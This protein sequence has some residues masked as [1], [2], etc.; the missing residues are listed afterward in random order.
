MK[1]YEL[2]EL[3][4]LS[5]LCDLALLDTKLNY[6]FNRFCND[7]EQYKALVSIGDLET[8]RIAKMDARNDLYRALVTL[9][10]TFEDGD[11]ETLRDL[12]LCEYMQG[13]Q[14]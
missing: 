13:W 6:L 3:C 2:D 4:S 10:E 7:L 8:A 11:A 5:D 9:D 12:Y 14:Y 1:R